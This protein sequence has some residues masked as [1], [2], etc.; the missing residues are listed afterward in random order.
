MTALLQTILNGLTVGSLYSLIAL[1]YSMVY[2]VLGMLNFAHGDV[3]MVGAYL[4]W[5]LAALIGALGLTGL[6]GGPALL[7]MMLVVAAAGAGF[8]GL[9]I[10]R[11]AYRPLRSATRLAPLISALGVSIIL[12]NAIM[13][14]FGTRA[15]VYPVGAALN[16]SWSL[17]AG[18]VVL[19]GPRTLMLAASLLLMLGLEWLVRRTSVGRSMRAVAEDREA[20]AFCGLDPDK[21]V[22]TVFFIGSALAGAGGVLVGV[23]YT[24]VDFFMGFGAGMKAFTA[25]VLGGIGDLRGAALGGLFLGIIESLG[26]AFVAPV[27]RDVITFSVL[28]LVLLVRPAGLFGRVATT[29]A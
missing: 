3:F 17:S 11:F 18:G 2:G 8:L 24:Q 4:G 10:E 7:A 23:Y 27:Y 22:A 26:V 16:L 15:K 21:V 5:G 19:S 25:A 29:R 14:I 1:G 12:E 28:I 9:G 13:L 20:A 6:A